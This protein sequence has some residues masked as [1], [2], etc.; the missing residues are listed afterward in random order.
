AAAAAARRAGR[1]AMLAILV[2]QPPLR[3]FAAALGWRESGVVEAYA[4]LNGQARAALI[5]T[6]A[7]PAAG[8]GGAPGEGPSDARRSA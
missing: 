8:E 2:D 4:R 5:A 6:A 1:S 7:L 3:G